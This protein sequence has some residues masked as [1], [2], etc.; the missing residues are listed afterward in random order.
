MGQYLENG[1][2]KPD[3]VIHNKEINEV[4]IIEVGITGDTS[5]TS[6]THRKILKYTEFKNVI[7]REWKLEK[8]DLIPVI[9]GVTG[10][11]R[12]KLKEDLER[13]SPKINIDHLQTEVVK[14]GVTI[15]KIVLSIKI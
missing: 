7:K 13:I 8:V 14:S 2:N 5:I 4:K 1:A 6:T 15:L 3:I 11:Y 9:I 10:L 12:K